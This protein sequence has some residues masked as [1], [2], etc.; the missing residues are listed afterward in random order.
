MYS[1]HFK[2]WM[3]VQQNFVGNHIESWKIQR[4]Q[5]SKTKWKNIFI[6]HND[7]YT[8]N[9]YDVICHRICTS[10]SLLKRKQLPVTFPPSVSNALQPPPLLPPPLLPSSPPSFCSSL[11]HSPLP[12]TQYTETLTIDCINEMDL[13]KNQS[14]NKLNYFSS[15]KEKNWIFYSQFFLFSKQWSRQKNWKIKIIR[16]FDK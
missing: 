2:L 9:V 13:N 16:A 12:H 10:F 5:P 15:R 8:I 3:K 14:E 1:S 7:V 6:T 4:N 11:T